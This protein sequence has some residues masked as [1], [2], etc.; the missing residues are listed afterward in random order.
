MYDVI[1][2]GGGI[3]GLWTSYHLAKENKKVILLEQVSQL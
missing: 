1:V 2:V 3:I